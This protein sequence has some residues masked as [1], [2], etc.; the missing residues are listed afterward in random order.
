MITLVV[1]SLLSS[2]ISE[3]AP[4][5]QYHYC[6][7][8]NFTPNSTYQSNLKLL[9]SSLSSNSSIE[10]GFYNITV[11]QNSSNNTIY[12]LFLCRGDVTTEVC[13]DCVATATKNIVQQFCPRGR[14]VV[15]W[16]DEC[17]LRYSEPNYFFIMNDPSFSKC[18]DNTTVAELD[19][20]KKLLA[21]VF[22]DSVTRA[23]SAQL[24]AKMFATKEAMFSSSLTLYSLVQCTPDI[25][26]FDCNKCL[27][28]AIANLPTD[29][30]GKQGAMGLYTSCSVRYDV[31]PFYRIIPSSP[32]PLPPP[33]PPGKRQSSSVRIIA[34]VTSIAVSVV[35]LTMVYCF[36]RRKLKKKYKVKEEDAAK[37]ITAEECFIFDLA[38][39]KA[40]TYNFSDE[41]KLGKGGF[42]VVYKGTF[43][44]GQEIAVKR[45][46]SSSKQ[47]VEEFKN[48]VSLLA[49]LQHRNLVRLL[50]FCLEGKE[51]ILV[52]EYVPNKSLDYFLFDPNKQRLLDWS[53]RYKIIGGIARGILYLHED[54]R[55]RIIHRD[56]KASNILLDEEMNPKVSDFGMA[57]IFEID[58]T[59]DNTHKIVGTYGYMP[60]EYAI[61]GL[62]SMKSDVY[63]FG[64]LILEIISGKKNSSFSSPS[65]SE[66]LLSYAW[67]HWRDGT[68]LELLD[69][70][71]RDSYSRDEVKRCLH[72]GLECIQ[73]SPAERP[74]M[75][76]IVLMLNSYSVSLPLPQRP[77]FFLHSRTET[78]MPIKELGSDQSTSNGIP[79][80]VNESSITE[81]YPR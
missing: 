12:G 43:P 28:G 70:T 23:Q 67:K 65:N 42:G 6:S 21:T 56:L 78:R 1:L 4:T 33:A 3:A 15:I 80:S 18:T 45:L 9:L 61:R 64:V 32:L 17:M 14:W 52:Y 48:E 57:R 8:E 53:N 77:A 10:S 63:S 71:L 16:Y 54:S 44:G 81:V 29:C 74:T 22:D 36:R 30:N 76:S 40:A 59:Q 25:S 49:K 72:I 60:P 58:Q 79:S 55:L 46:S 39:L 11:G 50:G 69:P 27:R 68:F 19:G 26:S 41:S 31:H 7:D 13:Q 75:A 51:K 38:T 24:G 66:N 35:L 47:G 5:Y 20:F 62:Y 73:E 37:E 2:I 34:I